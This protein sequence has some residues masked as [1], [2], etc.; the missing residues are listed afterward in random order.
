MRN[1]LSLKICL[2]L[3]TQVRIIR[4]RCEK[5]EI[6]DRKA[7]KLYINQHVTSLVSANLQ[8]ACR[9]GTTEESSVVQMESDRAVCRPAMLNYRL[10]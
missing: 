9:E 2:L 7:R 10:K 4:D 8:R 1:Q 5:L 3:A 6:A